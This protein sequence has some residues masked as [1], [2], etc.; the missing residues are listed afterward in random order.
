M[1]QPTLK[2]IAPYELYYCNQGDSGFDI[3]SN[4]SQTLTLCSGQVMTI[5]TGVYL[6]I[7]EGFE[8]QVRPKSSLSAKG[9]LAHFGTV[10]TGYRGELIVT[11][12]NL[13]TN[14][15]MHTIKVGDKI[16]Q[17]VL[18]PIVQAELVQVDSININ[19]ERG[20]G[21]HGSTN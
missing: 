7:P 6:E 5:A 8:V 15:F 1:T 19:T 18:V 4:A 2:Y 13:N 20:T 11:L 9:I 21:G 10:D 16:A 17:L 12:S 3:R 14:G